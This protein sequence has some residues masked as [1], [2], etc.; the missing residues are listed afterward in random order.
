MEKVTTSAIFLFFSRNKKKVEGKLNH[1]YFSNKPDFFS[2]KRNSCSILKHSTLPHTKE[3]GKRSKQLTRGI[4][5][6]LT[7]LNHQ[8]KS[9]K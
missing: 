8:R 5:W 7:R 6:G 9:R 1:G 3:K 2:I 4:S